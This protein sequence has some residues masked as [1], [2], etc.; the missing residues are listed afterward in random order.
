[1]ERGLA[2]PVATLKL[3]PTEI[4]KRV[5]LTFETTKDDLDD[6]EAAVFRASTGRQIAL[7]RHRHQ[8]NRGTDILINER[9]RNLSAAV[10][11]ALQALNFQAHDL[12]W[13]SPKVSLRSWTRAHRV[14]KFRLSS[15]TLRKAAG[16]QEHIERLQA[17][18]SQTLARNTGEHRPTVS[19]KPTMGAHKTEAPGRNR[20]VALSSGPLAPA[21]VRVLKLRRTPMGVSDILDGLLAN[22]YKFSSPEPKKNL[23]ARIYRLKGVKQ[24]G[25]GKFTAI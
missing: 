3:E 10:R 1:M 18:L 12:Q 6:V 8:P 23:F 22:G 9:S 20:P 4:T 2:R 11:D 13:T 21:V 16:I 19:K 24:V 25:P 15:A 14:P 5:G 7:V 17:E